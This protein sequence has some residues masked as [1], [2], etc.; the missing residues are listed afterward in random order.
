MG[1]TLHGS[2]T[3]DLNP[4]NWINFGQ[5]F[6]VDFLAGKGTED[7]EESQFSDAQQV[8]ILKQ[9]DEGVPLAEMCQ[10]T[11]SIG[12]RNTPHAAAGDEEVKAVRE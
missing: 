3:T 4:S 2:A 8:F 7:D 5:G 9:G 1:Q 11:I 12:R 6:P 10:A